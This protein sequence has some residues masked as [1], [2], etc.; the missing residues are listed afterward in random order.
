MEQ[1][2]KNEYSYEELEKLQKEGFTGVNDN[3]KVING[4]TIVPSKQFPETGL[5]IYVSG[6]IF[7]NIV[8]SSTLIRP[9][10][11]EFSYYPTIIAGR[12]DHRL[13]VISPTFLK[14]LFPEIRDSNFILTEDMLKKLV[15]TNVRESFPMA[16]WPEP[17]YNNEMNHE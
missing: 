8:I 2:F 16:T 14:D 12:Y 4:I 3:I 15:I 5:D 13:N 1:K 9:K 10:K 6:K 7:G 17:E 11:M